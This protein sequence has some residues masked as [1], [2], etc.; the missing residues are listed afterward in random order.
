MH[1]D[2]WEKIYLILKTIA[3]FIA[4]PLLSLFLVQRHEDKVLA[5]QIQNQQEQS[6]LQHAAAEAQLA[7]G[8]IPI[9]TH[10]RKEERQAALL[11]LSYMSPKV[12]ELMAEALL[13]KAQT[14]AEKVFAQAIHS[15]SVKNE[16]N[17]E[18]IRHLAFARQYRH[19]GLDA[20]A[21]REYFAALEAAPGATAQRSRKQQKEH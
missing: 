4:M 11:I 5:R 21:C 17:Q 3:V 14:P 9:I 8:L 1:K 12:G 19:V 13:V 6:R 15:T 20:N 7:Q 2:A 16:I 18:L 10:G